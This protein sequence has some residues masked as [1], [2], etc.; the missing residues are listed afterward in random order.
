[1]VFDE[2]PPPYTRRPSP[3]RAPGIAGFIKLIEPT[4][5][6]VDHLTDSGSSAVSSVSTFEY[7][8]YAGDSGI[9]YADDELEASHSNESN[10]EIESMDEI[11]QAAEGHLYTDTSE[12]SLEA[13]ELGKLSTMVNEA[14]SVIE[15]PSLD[16]GSFDSSERD[17]DYCA[18]WA[19]AVA[20]AE[21]GDDEPAAAG[22]QAN[23]LVPARESQDVEPASSGGGARNSYNTSLDSSYYASSEIE[24]DKL[25]DI[26]NT[27][28]DANTV[29]DA[30]MSDTPSEDNDMQVVIVAKGKGRAVGDVDHGVLGSPMSLDSALD[31]D[32]PAGDEPRLDE[33]RLDE[34]RLDE[35]RLYSLALAAAALT[36]APTNTSE[37]TPASPSTSCVQALPL[38]EIANQQAA[39]HALEADEIA[40]G[41]KLKVRNLEFV[42]RTIGSATQGKAPSENATAEPS[43]IDDIEM[44]EQ[45]DDDEEAVQGE[46]PGETAYLERL[47]FL[48]AQQPNKAAQKALVDV[49][50]EL[51]REA[52][53][54][55]GKRESKRRKR[56][57]RNDSCW[58]QD[59]D[60]KDYVCTDCPRRRKKQCVAL[61]G[62]IRIVI[63]QFLKL[64]K[65]ADPLPHGPPPEVAAP[66]ATAFYIKWDE[67]EKSEF[68]AI[69]A[70]IVAQQIVR[71]FPSICDL[72]E[73]HSMV[74]SHIKYL[75]ARYRCQTDPKYIAEE[76]NRR[77]SSSA[78]TR[79]QT[80]IN[81][82]P[83]LARHGRLIETL[84]L[85][86]TSSDEEDTTRSVWGVYAVKR[87]RQ[88]S[89][90]VHSLKRKLDLAWSIHFKGPGSKG[91]QARKRIDS[92]LVSKRRLNVTGLPLSCMDPG[93]LATLTDVQKEM[94]EF[95]DMEYDFGFPE[96]LLE[97]PEYM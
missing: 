66:T 34:S 20:A 13:S 82:V 3:N 38:K 71:E 12:S 22:S 47:R 87:R 68:N 97:T 6:D 42:S 54:E 94:Y 19:T 53:D 60:Q 85:E 77:R 35:S 24:V 89:H 55:K 37:P 36:G 26:V 4:D 51:A 59:E 23:E 79:K 52:E 39:S 43:T 70:R 67:S 50:E 1:M 73:M 63:W 29:E 16:L 45:S 9:L 46:T 62:Y 84:G 92:G 27:A 48:Y 56:K 75:R 65:K 33:S 30:S 93:W 83:A 40:A 57:S 25:V 95:R 7:S 88:L 81:A 21:S 44:P 14:S 61:A 80:I 74:T 86:G 17:G 11:E 90:D 41:R 18:S 2:P 96:E 76:S 72:D 10:G 5:G 49:L 58:D 32:T 15:W 91:N 78:R 28:E 31:A 8:E 69:A 64:K